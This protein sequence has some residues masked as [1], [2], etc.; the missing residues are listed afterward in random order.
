M[1]NK[2]DLPIVECID[3]DEYIDNITDIR[4]KIFVNELKI[5][6]SL[7]WDT[8][9]KTA[10]HYIV[11]TKSNGIVAYARLLSSGK[12]G[13]VAVLK[14]W[15]HQGIGSLLVSTI[16]KNAS[17]RNINTINLAS[18]FSVVQFYL[19]LGFHITGDT[20]FEAGIKHQAMQKSLN[21]LL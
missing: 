18:Q 6:K 5:P 12:L 2:N 10:V 8:L 7:E 4:N 19:Q 11:K 17:K 13:R 15:R 3:F 16:C 1:T 14:Q 20:F 9:D 21:S